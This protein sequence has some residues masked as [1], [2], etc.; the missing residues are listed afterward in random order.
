MSGGGNRGDFDEK[1]RLK[2]SSLLGEWGKM[3]VEKDEE[4]VTNG[5]S[6]EHA[7]P[8]HRGKYSHGWCHSISDPF[9]FCII[10]IVYHKTGKKQG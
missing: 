6:E 2:K 9:C 5:T 10:P 7:R 8:V 1:D 3:A 4:M